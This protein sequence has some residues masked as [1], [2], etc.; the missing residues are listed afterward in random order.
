L[1][2][3][4][5]VIFNVEDPGKPTRRSMSYINKINLDSL[6]CLVDN[7]RI[8]GGLGFVGYIEDISKTVGPNLITLLSLNPIELLLYSVVNFVSARMA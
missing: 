6:K 8:K 7:D 3:F 1:G 2:V 5:K 4:A